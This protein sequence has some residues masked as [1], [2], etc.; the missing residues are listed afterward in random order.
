MD[1]PFSLKSFVLFVPFAF[2]DLRFHQ[3]DRHLIPR[4]T[5]ECAT[6]PFLLCAAPLF[7]EKWDFDSQALIPTIRD[8]LLHD[9]SRTCDMS[10][11]G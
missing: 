11:C 2:K 5:F 4:A 1:A 7:E 8:L 10:N 9:W 3:I 6:C